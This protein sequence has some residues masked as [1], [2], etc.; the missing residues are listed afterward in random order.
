MADADVQPSQSEKLSKLK[1]L[2]E[3]LDQITEKERVGFISLVTRYMSVK[4]QYIDWGSIQSPT[5]VVPYD[6]LPPSPEDISDRKNILEKLVVL[7]LN[8]AL[9]TKLGFSGP[10]SNVKVHR[11]CTFLDLIVKQINVLN[12]KYRCNVPLLLMN[13]FHTNDD[14]LE[15]I[16]KYSKLKVEIHTFNQ[17]QYPRLVGEDF[18]PFPCKGQTGK[19]G[20]YSPGGGDVFSSLMNSGKLDALLAKGKEYVFISNSDNLGAVV[21]LKILNHL[22]ENN[23]EYCM[24]VTPKTSA[25]GKGG[26]LIYY[27]ERVQ[28]LEIAQVPDEYVSEFKSIKN[29]ET[30]NTNNL[31]VNLKAIK[32]VVEA[33]ALKMEIIPNRKEIDGVKT[34][35]LKTTAGAAIK[36]FRQIIGINVPRSRFFPVKTKSELR[37]VKS[38]SYT[39]SDGVVTLKSN[40]SNTTSELESE[41]KKV[42]ARNK[43]TSNSMEKALLELT[44]NLPAPNFVKSMDP[45]HVTRPYLLRIP[46]GSSESYPEKDCDIMLE[47]ED[48]KL[49]V[50]K[51]LLK[52]LALS[53]GW[54]QFTKKKKLIVGDALFF[55]IVEPTKFKEIIIRG[56]GLSDAGVANDL[57]ARVATPHAGDEEA[58]LVGDVSCRSFSTQDTFFPAPGWSFFS[59]GREVPILRP[60]SVVIGYPCGYEAVP[61]QRYDDLLQ[62][63]AS[64]KE[65]AASQ[66]ERILQLEAALAAPQPNPTTELAT[67]DKDDRGQPTQAAEP[68]NMDKDDRGQPNPVTELA[69]EHKDD[70][71]Q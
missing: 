50:V 36:F 47:D 26:S 27:D 9:G 69:T 39:L 59:Q 67:V 30:F 64:L 51:F 29:F 53:G 68:A 44:K 6:K 40:S 49:H 10:R 60:S 25:S 52:H 19:N 20:W 28:L 31:W 58:P 14:T 23:F 56:D 71:G 32:K 46:P 43:A 1:C 41:L 65:L 42:H 22:T 3:G 16:K 61:G 45:S 35:Q 54:G 8:G 11:S 17:S 12:S 15:I 55:Q 33:D 7:K 62:M 38:N 34:L 37:Y 5:N 48:G 13:S 4:A 57:T 24:E 63:V 18:M 2:V 70:T 66:S 21:D